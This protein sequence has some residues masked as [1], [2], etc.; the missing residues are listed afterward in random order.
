[1][2]NIFPTLRSG[3]VARYPVEQ[4]TSVMTG[5]VQFVNASEQRWQTKGPI[6]SFVFKY[7]N[8]NSYD[9]GIMI[10]FF[11]QMK[12]A[13]VDAALAN[14][15]SVTLEGN[16]YNYCTFVDDQFTE[17]EMKTNRYSFELSIIMVRPN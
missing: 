4:R 9:L 3:Q 17:V 6:Q 10:D 12:G 8:V 16:T 2:P 13:F 15:F 7:S 14:T 11:N 1:M 5:M